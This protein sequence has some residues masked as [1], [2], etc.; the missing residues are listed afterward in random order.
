MTDCEQSMAVLKRARKDG[1]LKKTE[2]LKV[3]DLVDIIDVALLGHQEPQRYRFGWKLCIK[4]V[5]P[6]NPGV[7]LVLKSGERGEG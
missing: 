3:Y 1:C 2:K 4:D 7:W 6:D 5:K